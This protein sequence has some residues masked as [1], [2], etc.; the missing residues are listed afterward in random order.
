MISADH[1]TDAKTDAKGDGGD[2]ANVRGGDSTVGGA[3]LS[4][5][6]LSEGVDEG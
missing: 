2:Q 3:D 5:D 1:L 6:D 4:L